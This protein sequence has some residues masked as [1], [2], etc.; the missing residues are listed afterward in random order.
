MQILTYLHN[1]GATRK[2]IISKVCLKPQLNNL[3]K[4]KFNLGSTEFYGLS[5]K[6]T[7]DLWSTNTEMEQRE[8]YI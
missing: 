8:K 7:L 4:T 2:D 3:W 5:M 6:T 1:G